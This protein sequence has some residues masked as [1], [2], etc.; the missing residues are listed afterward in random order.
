MVSF[1]YSLFNDGSYLRLLVLWFCLF[2]L[3]IYVC[4]GFGSLVGGSG[5]CLLGVSFKG[6]YTFC[7][8]AFF[9]EY[10]NQTTFSSII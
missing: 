5:V 9:V 7:L 2:I 8:L 4:F 3:A 1:V 6:L 10:L